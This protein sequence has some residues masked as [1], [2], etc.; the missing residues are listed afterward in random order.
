[1]TVEITLDGGVQS[2]YA[3]TGNDFGTVAN[4]RGA[5][6]QLILEEIHVG[7][8][9]LQTLVGNGQR[10]SR[11]AQ[12]AALFHQANRSILKH[13]GIDVEVRNLG[14]LTQS[15]QYSVCTTTY[16]TLQVEETL[17]DKT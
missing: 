13:L 10:A 15:T 1:M 5:Q 9:I 11:S 2:A 3:D 17:G 4:L 12:Y 16:T 8:N 7:V 6:N 14:T